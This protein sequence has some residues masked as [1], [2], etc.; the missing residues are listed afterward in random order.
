[1]AQITVKKKNKVLNIEDTRLESYLKQGYDQIDKDGKVVEKAT[2]GKMVSLAEFNKA[3]EDLDAA[4]EK[5][6]ELESR[7]L[8]VELAEAKKEIKNLKTEN[9][10]LKKELDKTDGGE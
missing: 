7:D 1:M 3:V 5:I 2:G 8:E 6:A 4:N 10:K 9:T